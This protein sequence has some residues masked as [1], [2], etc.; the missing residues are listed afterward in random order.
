MDYVTDNGWLVSPEMFNEIK[1]I[2]PTLSL[3][4]ILQLIDIMKFREAKPK[5]NHL[6]RG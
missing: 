1:E 6:E 4:E 3:R 5:I 2:C